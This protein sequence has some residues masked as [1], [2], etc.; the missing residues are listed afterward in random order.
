M[1]L[2]VL[3][4]D[5]TLRDLKHIQ[6]DGPRMAYLFFFNK[7]GHQGLTLETTHAIKTHMGETFSEWISCSLHFAVDPMPLAEGWHR[8]MHQKG[9]GNGQGWGIQAGWF[10]TQPPVSLIPPLVGNTLSAGVRN[11]PAEDMEC[12]WATRVPTS[13]P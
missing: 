5:P 2:H 11:G 6:V 12:G 9:G 8:M 1:V 7:Q 4:S 3:K 10:L 13:Y